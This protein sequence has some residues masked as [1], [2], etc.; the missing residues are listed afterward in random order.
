MTV[1]TASLMIISPA[2]PQDSV[3]SENFVAQ[4]L[5]FVIVRLV[6]EGRVQVDHTSRIDPRAGT[7]LA[8][9]PSEHSLRVYSNQSA[10]GTCGNSLTRYDRTARPIPAPIGGSS[11]GYQFVKSPCY[12]V[13]T[14]NGVYRAIE[15]MQ[16]IERRQ[17]AE[18]IEQ[19]R[20][21]IEELRAQRAG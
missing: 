21:E 4:D 16:Q 18:Q 1:V 9:V 6:P 5:D 19:L 14:M 2:N 17:I 12:A 11:P 7:R 13:A 10:T 20:E 15:E 8:V 3:P